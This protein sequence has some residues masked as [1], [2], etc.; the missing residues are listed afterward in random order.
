MLLCNNKERA[1]YCYKKDKERLKKHI[2]RLLILEKDYLQNKDK[3]NKYVYDDKSGE[4][5]INSN[6]ELL[7]LNFEELNF[8]LSVCG[9]EKIDNIY[10][11]KD[12]KQIIDYLEY[13]L[14]RGD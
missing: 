4:Y 5:I 12:D 7:Q 2:T 1:I 10:E 11:I 9:Y 6:Y 13:L 8:R 3:Y 14:E